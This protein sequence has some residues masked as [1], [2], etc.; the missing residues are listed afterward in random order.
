V[1]STGKPDT[2]GVFTGRKMKLTTFVVLGLASLLLIEAVSSAATVPVPPPPTFKARS[3][4]L[5]DHDSGRTLA[6]SNADERLDPASITK[7]MTAYAVFHAL[8]EGKLTLK[9]TAHIS[10]HA[11]RAEGS[12]TFLQ[13]G[14]QV[15]VEV[16]IQGMIVQSGNDATIALAERVGGTEETF[17]ALMNNYAKQLGMKGSHFVNSSGLPSPEHYMTARDMAILSSA[18]IREFPEYYRW[19]SQREFTWNNIRQENRNGLLVRDP[20]VDG[21]KT[22]HT[23]TAGYCLVSSAKR[24]NM[25]LIAVVMG[26]ASMKARED[27]SQALLNYGY[28]F[29]ETQKLRAS[30]EPL[31]TARVWKAEFTP[32]QVGLRRDLFITVPRGQIPNLKTATSVQPLLIAPLSAQKPIGTFSVTYG[33]QVLEKRNVYPLKDV[34]QGGWWRRMVDAILLWFE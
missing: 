17:A 23:E 27:A 10:E 30:R 8:K 4:I 31:Q 6:E 28:N 7:L 13:V 32:V 11:W 9:E 3:Y 21:V 16:L 15:P 20:T 26:T 33:D 5:V 1:A 22:G 2:L 12:R 29:F 34:P 14:T 19:Y 24:N 25:R 18:I